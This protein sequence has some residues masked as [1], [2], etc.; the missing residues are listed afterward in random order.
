[1]ANHK[2]AGLG[3]VSHL[4]QVQPLE[5]GLCL[6]L[7]ICLARGGIFCLRRMFSH[8]KSPVISLAGVSCSSCRL[9]PGAT[10]PPPGCPSG[11]LLSWCPSDLRGCPVLL[12]PGGSQGSVLAPGPLPCDF[13]YKL[14]VK[15]SQ[16]SYLQPSPLLCSLDPYIQPLANS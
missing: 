12:M 5:P 3:A 13:K 11:T 1:M 8:P 2:G 14:Y 6:P 7:R 9:R 15:A 4:L 10:L 16:I